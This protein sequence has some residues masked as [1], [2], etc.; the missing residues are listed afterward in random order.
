MDI[1]TLQTTGKEIGRDV[2]DAEFCIFYELDYDVYCARCYRGYTTWNVTRLDGGDA[3]CVRYHY[4][5]KRRPGSG[6][7]HRFASR[8]EQLAVQ[9][10]FSFEDIMES[11]CRWEMARA[12]NTDDVWAARYYERDFSWFPKYLNE[13]RASEVGG[14]YL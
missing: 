14:S 9:F 3:A 13:F 6:E 11:L 12:C 10:G 2:T 4:N 7:M 5:R 1:N 8:V